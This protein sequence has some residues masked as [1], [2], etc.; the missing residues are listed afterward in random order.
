LVTVGLAAELR[1]D[2]VAVNSL[3]PRTTIDTAAIRNV[4]GAELA[5]RSRTPEIMADAAYAILTKPSGEATG[6]FFLDDEVLR[7]E[8]VTD[9]AKYRIG[10]TE[11]DLQLDFW[12][13]PA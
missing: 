9:F 10:G 3:W 12:V 8:G 11:D 2:G 1:K 13:D 4:V 5:D 6:N 7:A